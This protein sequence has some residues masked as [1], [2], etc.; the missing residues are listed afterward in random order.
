MTCMKN[1]SFSICTQHLACSLSGICTG[2][3]CGLASSRCDRVPLGNLGSLDQHHYLLHPQPSPHTACGQPPLGRQYSHTD[4]SSSSAPHHH[5]GSRTS[6]S[7]R[8]GSFS[9]TQISPGAKHYHKLHSRCRFTNNSLKKIWYL[10][11]SCEAFQNITSLP[12]TSAHSILTS[13][14][15]Q[16]VMQQERVQ[17]L[18]WLSFC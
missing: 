6:M 3:A 14:I 17:S 11:G 16:I 7:L 8:V 2:N 15:F 18:I 9:H 13:S 1:L 12:T 4:L 10:Q 5:K